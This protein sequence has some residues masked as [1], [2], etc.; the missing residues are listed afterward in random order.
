MEKYNR[1]ATPPADATKAIEAGRLKGKTDINPQWKIE[2]MTKEYGECGRGWWFDIVKENVVPLND[3]QILLFMQVAVFTADGEKTSNPVIGCGGDFIVKKNK[4][5]LEPND[6]AYKMCLTDALGNALKCLGV[7]ATVFRGKYDT[8]YNKPAEP[9]YVRKEN[10]CT[11]VLGNNNRWYSLESMSLELLNKVVND[12]RY[13]Q[14]H[15][16]ARRLMMKK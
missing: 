13:A 16:E 4:N 14:C 7:G 12:S 5:G 10:N 8:K 9:I 15:D 2:A 1:L 6:E 3:G 11:E